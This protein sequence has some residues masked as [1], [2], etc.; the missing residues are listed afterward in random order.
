MEH[1]VPCKGLI[2]QINYFY[3]HCNPTI[4]D[5]IFSFFSDLQT[6][7]QCD[8]AKYDRKKGAAVPLNEIIV[9]LFLSKANYS[10]I[11]FVA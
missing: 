1:I 11:S 9:A 6:K 10:V 4:T 2:R 3:T 5:E 8:V 7:R